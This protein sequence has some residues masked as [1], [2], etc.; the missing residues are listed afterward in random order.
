MQK[1]NIN[2]SILIWAIF[3]SLII[4]VTFIWISTQI[5]KNLRNNSDLVNEFKLENQIKNIISS[6]SINNKFKNQFLINWE[7]IIFDPFDKHITTLK[8]WEKY[9]WKVNTGSI[10]TIK[11]LEGSPVYYTQNTSS[12]LVVL[13][14]SEWFTNDWTWTFII[15]NLWWYSKIKITTNVLINYLSQYEN[16]TIY[17]KIW[18]KEIIKTKWQIKL[19]D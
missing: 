6:W 14:T 8:K 1:S 13:W 2:W 4:T 15:E 3:L 17:K 18:N 7:K 12:W 11:I 16:Y 9:I 19:F 5:N 10:I